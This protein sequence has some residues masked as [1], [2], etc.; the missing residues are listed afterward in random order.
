MKQLINNLV[1]VACILMITNCKTFAQS[2]TNKIRESSAVLPVMSEAAP[3]LVVEPPIPE[4]LAVGSVIIPYQTINMRI[5]PVFGDSAV[6]APP[7]IGHLHVTLD[8]NPWHW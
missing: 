8:D 3:K 7:R 5:L 4:K 2:S 6:P 1:F